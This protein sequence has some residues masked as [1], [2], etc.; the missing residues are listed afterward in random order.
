[1][2]KFIKRALAVILAITLVA[3]VF[4]GCSNGRK[5]A[6]I[7]LFYCSAEA[8]SKYQVDKIGEELK[9]LGYTTKEYSFA[10]S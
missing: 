9:K 8:N 5:Q 1:M 4:A 7:G 6:D 2:S 10:D 3:A